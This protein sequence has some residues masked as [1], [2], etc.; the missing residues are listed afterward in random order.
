MTP[1]ASRLSPLMQE[2]SPVTQN[3]CPMSDSLS[4]AVGS[5]T[6]EGIRRLSNFE[7]PG[8]PCLYVIC[9]KPKPETNPLDLKILYFGEHEDLHSQD[10]YANHPKLRCWVSEGGRLDALYV[11][12]HALPDS[13]L[14]ERKQ[15]V[16]DLLEV[17][18]PVCNI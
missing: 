5:V 4:F 3:Q 12:F 6:F 11:G 9:Y 17:F 2:L 14:A 15:A 8:G 18:R 16:F 10:F 7:A 13:S 1:F